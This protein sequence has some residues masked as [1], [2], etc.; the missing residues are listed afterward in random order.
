MIKDVPKL[1][2]LASLQRKLHLCL[3]VHA[4]QPQHNLLR[5]LGFLVEHGFGLT[6]VTGLLAVVTPLSL[7][8]ERSLSRK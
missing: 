3:A 4:L 1:E 8:E 6:T 5:G 7:G 2:V